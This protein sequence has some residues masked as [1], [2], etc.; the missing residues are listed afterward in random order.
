MNLSQALPRRAMQGA[1]SLS[2]WSQ[3]LPVLASII[4]HTGLAVTAMV[5]EFSPT[6]LAA[7][8]M[9][10]RG[11]TA[12]T[13]NVNVRLVKL[14]VEGDGFNQGR[15]RIEALDET[16]VQPQPPAVEHARTPLPVREPV[17]TDSEHALIEPSN[18]AR[19]DAGGPSVPVRG[20]GAD[21]RA[22]VASFAAQPLASAMIR[23]T[24]QPVAAN[25]PAT[26]STSIT[27]VTV[28]PARAEATLPPA[29]PAWPQPAQSPA[30]AEPV[31]P[32][33][34]RT[35]SPPVAADSALSPPTRADSTRPGEPSRP[36]TPPTGVDRGADL[37]DLPSPVYPPDSRRRGEQGTVVLE[38]EILANGRVGEIRVIESPGHPRL[39][40]AAIAAA[41]QAKLRP[42]AVAGKTVAQRI[43]VPF[44]FVI[45]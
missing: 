6:D 37:A 16:P 25:K 13:A 17:P 40:E 18:A 24:E 35:E 30:I 34:L 27:R 32:P 41:R 10:R 19:A 11:Q 9:F 4:L 5:H 3:A 22:G 44:H 21:R 43:R 20:I 33:L 1:A 31:A 15:V 26:E 14:T 23:A 28:A 7:E 42:A 38:I 2:A 12:S 36:A 8:P 29:S 45:R 39:V